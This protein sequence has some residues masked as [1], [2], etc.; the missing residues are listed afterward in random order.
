MLK[1]GQMVAFTRPMSSM[2]IVLEAVENGALNR[3]DIEQVTNLRAGQISSAL[4]NLAFIGAVQ[5]STD[6]QGRHIYVPPGKWNTP[7]A[8]CLC[9]VSSI[10]NVR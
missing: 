10:F 4:Y 9:G 7:V 5:H 1:K 3:Y 6:E 8:K 2:K